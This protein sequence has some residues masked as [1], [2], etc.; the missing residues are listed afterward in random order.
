MRRSFVFI[1]VTVLLLIL[2]APAAA[3]APTFDQ[4]IDQLI[5][6]GYPQKIEADLNGFGTSDLGM[7]M[8]GTTA[9]NAA[10]EYIAD[11][12]KRLG[13]T[14]RADLDFEDERFGPEL[15]PALIW[16][17]EAGDWPA[18]RKAASA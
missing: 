11:E 17:I 13:M 5:E 4:A 16:R 8:G 1:L 10:A 7:R 14:R 6:Q 2:L 18:A 9:D 15:N 3:Q 12:M